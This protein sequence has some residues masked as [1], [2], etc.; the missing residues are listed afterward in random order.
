MLNLNPYLPITK[1]SPR[2]MS[3][4]EIDILSSN[5]FESPAEVPKE[6]LLAIVGSHE[7]LRNEI[8]GLRAE[9]NAKDSDGSASEDESFSTTLVEC[10]MSFSPPMSNFSCNTFLRIL[11]CLLLSNELVWCPL[12]AL[13]VNDDDDVRYRCANGHLPE[14]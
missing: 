11:H 2:K 1:S 14:I 12:C 9:I 8:D 6:D 3:E 10:D 13:V 7:N 4:E 5:P